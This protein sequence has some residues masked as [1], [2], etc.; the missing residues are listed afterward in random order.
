M[1]KN[2]LKSLSVFCLFLLACAC[3][4][5]AKMA[6]Y[7]EQ[8]ATSCNPQVLEAVDG[9]IKATYT[10]EFPAKFFAPKAILNI[11]PVLVGQKGEIV[12][13]VLS[14]QG[15]KVLSNNHVISYENGGKISR[16]VVYKYAPGLEKAHLELRA[17]VYSADMSKQYKFPIAFKIAEGTNCTYM[18]VKTNGTPSFEKDN[19]QKVIAEKKESQILYTINQANVRN[20]QLTT[21]EM[22]E[23]EQFLKD[24]KADERRTLVSNDIIAYASPD[25]LL[26]KN[27]KL[28]EE[29][30]KTAKTAFVKRISKKAD[31]KDIPLNVSQISEDWEGFQELVAAS[32]IQDKELILRVLSMYS[33]PVV[34]EREIKNMSS[35]FKTLADKVLP[36]LRRARFIANVE[37]K[38]Y[39]DEELIQLINENI[40]Q[41]DEEALLYGATLVDK[42]EAKAAVYKKATSKYN[43]SRAYNNLAALSL[44]EGKTAEAKGYLAKMTNKSASYYNNM[45]VVA[46]QEKNYEQALSLLA[47]TDSSVEK[48]AKANLGAI[49][50]LKG[51][52][53][54]AVK[55][56]A[57]TN[58]YNEALANIL[59]NN[60]SK[61]SSILTA[62]CPCQ[63][64]LRAIIAARSGKNS[65]AKA[66][67]EKASKNDKLAERAKTDIEF[68]K[69]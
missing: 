37:Y 41:L 35:V 16:D 51:A 32:D 7:A 48:E 11:T 30:A 28:S 69:L 1:K 40:D 25:G 45:A 29:R 43:S 15:D 4:N 9:N 13:E 56:L 53:A 60:L 27:A 23:F 2:L 17:V 21:K 42:A 31:V 36:A 64:Y 55:S 22:K 24:V 12:G 68:A 39:T 6:E 54:D 62:D 58:S 44:K 47:K 20:N 63:S 65:E 52:Y 59:V 50:I 10:I 34:R 61:A 18:L 26:D 49:S 57:G 3:S 14:L 46:M 67:L 38:N 8:V 5:P 19:Y 66:Q 33:D